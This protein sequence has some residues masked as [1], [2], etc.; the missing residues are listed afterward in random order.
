MPAI[1]LL[2]LLTR[3][4][5]FLTYRNNKSEVMRALTTSKDFSGVELRAV[6]EFIEKYAYSKGIPFDMGGLTSAIRAK[7]DSIVI[8]VPFDDD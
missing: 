3:D 7:L 4:I 2:R 6:T 1:T 5:K 8:D